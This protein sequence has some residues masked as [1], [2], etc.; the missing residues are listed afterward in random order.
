MSEASVKPKPLNRLQQYC[1]DFYNEVSK[2]AIQSDD[3]SLI[4]T[5][6]LHEAT[7]AAGIPPS[8]YSAI[9]KLLTASGCVA[10]LRKGT[11][12]GP[13]ELALL[14][15]PMEDDLSVDTTHLTNPNRAVTLREDKVKDI[16]DRLKILEAWRESQSTFNVIEALRNHEN[17]LNG[18]E[19]KGENAKAT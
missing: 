4:W 1:I 13:S 14:R 10:V 7:R 2:T 18:L 19:A 11:R 6:Y 12:A 8:N 3:G 16:E 17:R 9:R 15:A 5:G